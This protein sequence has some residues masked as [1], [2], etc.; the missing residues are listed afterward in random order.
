MR[1]PR[2]CNFAFVA[3][4]LALIATV[5]L[6]GAASAQQASPRNRSTIWDMQLGTPVSELPE[7]EFVDPACGTNGGPPGLRL[8]G[9]EQF[10]RCRPE[11]SGLREI[12]FRYD[13]ELETIARAARDPDAVAR[14]N[15]MVVL[16]Q[17]VILSLLV[18]PAG[19][20][21]GFRI[22]TD[23]HAEQDLRV[24]AYRVAMA[25]TA[26]FGTD[27]WECN[28]LPPTAGE[29]PIM[30]T[31]VKRMCRKVADGQQI[32]VE[33]RHYYKSGQALLDPNTGRTTV[34]QF[35]SAARIELVRTESLQK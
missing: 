18:D 12:W 4:A 21:Q 30:G 20:V 2:R 25:F 10:E 11:T 6:A 31:F 34:N 5:S 3:L 26:R 13:D 8:D 19:L 15:A 29:T 27:G 7:E 22:F 17:P 28:D 35:E 9:F 1:A 32:T 33:S 14:N 16:G 23:P 24:D